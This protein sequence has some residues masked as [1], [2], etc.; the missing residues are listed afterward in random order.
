MEA[1]LIRSS[2]CLVILYSIYRIFFK[3]D[4]HHQLKRIIALICILF[5][6]GFLFIPLGGLMVPDTYPQMMNVVFMQGSEGIQ[7]GLSKIITD[8][9]TNIY[10]VLYFIG[11]SVFALRSL[12]GV[13]TIVKWYVSSDKIKKWGFTVAKVDKNIAPFTFFNILF[14]GKQEF[15]EEAM[16]ALIVHEQYHKHQYHSIDT[17]LLELLTILY[18]FNPVVWL[19]QRDIKTE[20]EYMADEEV[21]KKGFDVLDYQYLLFQTRTGVSLNLGSNFSSKVN[22]KKRLHMMNKEKI[23]TKRSYIKALMLLPIMGIILV[24]SGFLEANNNL[25][26][27]IKALKSKQSL[28]TLPGNL[29]DQ[30][31]NEKLQ[32]RIRGNAN[33]TGVTPLFILKKGKKEEKISPSFMQSLKKDQ[34]K[35]VFVLKGESAIRKYGKEGK[36]GVVI[37]E[38]KKDE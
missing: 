27:E 2:I 9:M 37:I 12:T 38:L 5:A 17:V 6:C 22:L 29:R 14:I 11:M 28:D 20:H 32:F 30:I 1:Y 10:L 8:N 3:N 26:L 24:T 21:L 34:L 35:S 23:K 36:N 7:E 4:P 16:K 19:F 31:E 15:H 13:A 33:T 25:S 18:W